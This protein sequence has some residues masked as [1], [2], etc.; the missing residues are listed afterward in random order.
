MTEDFIRNAFLLRSFRKAV[1]HKVT[2][3]PKS[4][5]N[6][7]SSS[8]RPEYNKM[9]FQESPLT[10]YDLYSPVQYP[11]WCMN[12]FIMFW[13]I[14]NL[15]YH[16][17]L[18][19]LP[20]DGEVRRVYLKLDGNKRNNV[21]IY[22]MQ[23]LV[24]T[25]AFAAQVY[26]AWELVFQWKATTTEA[27]FKSLDMAAQFIVILYTW[28]LIFRKKIGLPLLT[29][30][31]TT[32]LLL[33]L[34]TASF[35]DTHD[36]LYL[37][38]SVMLGFHATVEQLTF[39]ALFFFRLKMYEKSLSFWFFFSAAQSFLFKS[40]VTLVATVYFSSSVIDGDFEH[41]G[42]WGTFWK[43][44]FPPLLLCLYVSQIY[45]CKILYLLGRRC[46]IVDK[47]DEGSGRAIDGTNYPTS[48]SFVSEEEEEEDKQEG[49][50]ERKDNE[51]RGS[52]IV[53]EV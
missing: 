6:L 35:F 3:F 34:S 24:T 44:C 19:G 47:Q 13:V 28:E 32:I 21:V 29:H 10:P 8:K 16:I 53:F 1:A 49:T 12:Y 43:I 22:V 50:E 11:W 39:V 45:A 17:L 23:L 52:E 48:C 40:I 4:N 2:Q 36:V 33:Q 26:G 37:R 30:H 14:S 51:Q 5:T 18:K 46:Q 27:R 38:F 7:I 41:H 25:A 42:A 15:I 20:R 9:K 31:I